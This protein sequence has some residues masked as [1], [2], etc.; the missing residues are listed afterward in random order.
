MNKKK[1]FVVAVLAVFIVGMTMTSV[2]ASGYIKTTK[3]SGTWRINHSDQ[4]ITLGSSTYIGKC[5][6]KLKKKKHY[7]V[8]AH[9]GARIKFV[10]WH[11]KKRGKYY[12]QTTHG[13][14]RNGFTIMNKYN[15]KMRYIYI[16]Y[17]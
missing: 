3:S 2:S 16:S 11:Y 1:L 14:I 8:Y 17:Y 13:T 6:A 5:P 12:Y 7:T 10:N 4:Y 15:T 9:N